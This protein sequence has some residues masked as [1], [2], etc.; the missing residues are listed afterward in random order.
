M[1]DK[2]IKTVTE[3]DD[4]KKLTTYFKIELKFSSRLTRKLIR[5]GY[6]NLNGERGYARNIIK[7]GDVIEINL[8]TEDTQDIEAQDVPI[9]VVYEDDDI[10]LVNKP[11]FMVV[12]PTKSHPDSTLANG[13]VHYFRSRGDNY[14]VRL[15]NRIDRDTSGLVM[16]AKSQFAHMAMAQQLESNEIEKYYVTVVKGRLEGSGTIDKPIDKRS[17]DTVKREVMEDGYRAVTHY[18]VLKSGEEMSSVLIRLETGKT[19]QIRVHMSYIGH[20]IVGDS[21][22]GT[23]SD[24]INRQALHAYK[25]R[26]DSLRDNVR[27]EVIAPIPED[28]EKLIEM[29]K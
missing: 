28:M 21:L 16:V 5:N 23:E 20:P 29:I 24:L 13:I 7:T 10:L 26:F 3:K 12:H 4:G 11:P 18:E 9:N 22:Y 6:V 19:H 1:K 2:L 27:Q 25:L 15:V 8:N 14:I 17:E